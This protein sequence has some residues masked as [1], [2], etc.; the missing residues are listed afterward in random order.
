[1]TTTTTTT[2]MPPCSPRPRDHKMTRATNEDS[3][4]PQKTTATKRTHITARAVANNG[5]CPAYASHSPSAFNNAHSVQP[6]FSPRLSLSLSLFQRPK[7]RTHTRAR[8]LA[9]LPGYVCAHARTNTCARS[10]SRESVS[11]A[12]RTRLRDFFAENA[13]LHL[14]LPKR[15]KTTSKKANERDDDS[16]PYI[17]RFGRGEKRRTVFTETKKATTTTTTRMMM[18]MMMMKFASR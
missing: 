6:I 12:D 1:M 5:A 4:P 16:L 11:Y 17:R 2:K 3:P 13:R 10:L 14:L 8:A 7:R 15:K 18:M 9:S